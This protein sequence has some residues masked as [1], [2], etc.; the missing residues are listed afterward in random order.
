MHVLVNSATT[1]T[2][3]CSTCNRTLITYEQQTGTCR[4]PR[5]R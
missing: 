4:P 2:V 1:R 5:N 3:F